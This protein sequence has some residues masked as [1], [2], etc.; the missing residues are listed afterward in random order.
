MGGDITLNSEV[1]KGTIFRLEIPVVAGQ[2]LGVVRR[3]DQ[4]R[5]VGLRPGQPAQRLLIVDD[6][7]NNRDWLNKLL[8]SMGFLVREADN[9]EAAIRIWEEWRP[10]LILMDI[11]MPIMDGLEATR[12]IRAG[13]GN[14]GPVILA[15]SASAMDEDRNLGIQSGVDDFVPKP[16][17]ED[18][19]LETIRVRLG[20]VYLYVGDKLSQETE[21]VAALASALNGEVLTKLP[22]ELMDQLRIAVL[23]GENDRLDELIGK[24][25]EQDA[26]FARTLRG[27]AD[28]YEYDALIQLLEVG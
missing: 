28:K 6:E 14:D 9:G 4:R 24:V 19:L 21:S 20:I 11:R 3:A 22:A 16:C 18:Q 15:V 23:N 2:A 25:M 12:R 13:Q 27:L 17:R 8:T 5:V 7:R 10:Q 1:G 26:A